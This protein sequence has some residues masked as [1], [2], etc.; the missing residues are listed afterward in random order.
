MESDCRRGLPAA[1]AVIP[2]LKEDHMKRRILSLLLAVVMVAGM[3]PAV[4]AAQAPEE[5]TTAETIAETTQDPATEEVTDAEPL[6]RREKSEIAVTGDGYPAVTAI[7][8]T[9][10]GLKLTWNAFPGA[11]KYQVFLRKEAGGWK[12]IGETTATSYLHKKLTNNT[13]YTYT[14]RAV[15]KKGDFISEGRSYSARW[16]QVPELLRCESTPSGQKLVWKSVEGAEAYRIF[17][18]S[19]TKWLFAGTTETS[20]CINSRVTSGKAY[21]Y[22]VRCWDVDADAPLSY[23]DTKGIIGAYYSTP[24]ITAFNAV[25]GGVSI[26]WSKVSGATYYAVFRKLSKGWKKLGVTSRLSMNDLGIRY[27]ARYTYTVRCVNSQGKPISGYVKNGWSF[28]HLAAPKITSVTYRDKVYTI[29]WKT[30]QTASYYRVYRKELGAGWTCLGNTKRNVFADKKAAKEGV[31]TYAIR[32]MDAAGNYLTYFTDTGVYYKMGICA[33]GPLNGEQP[34][35]NPRYTC[36]VSEAQLRR[37]VATVASGWQGANEGSIYHSEILSFYNSRRPLAGNHTV[38]ASDPWAAAFA[39][40]VWIRA[41]LSQYIGAEY[42][43]GRFV[44]LAKK[45]KIWVESDSYLPKVGDAIVYSWSDTGIGE[46]TS[47]ANHMGIV[48]AVNGSDFVVTEGD[49]GTGYVGTH[50]RVVNSQYIRGYIAPNYKQ[51]AQYISLKARYS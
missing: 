13:V 14:V 17:I 25:N 34:D 38:Q 46:C 41:G 44:E 27:S 21:A 33:V 20:Y 28:T 18:K 7:A 49:A 5:E 10:T 36:A 43:C 37:M 9:V 29:R 30:Q 12:K 23:F 50:D 15:N 42:S 1:A 19:G 40:A 8:P 48:T 47:S 32:T 45:N 22:T 2:Y 51:I 16:L 31:Y 35:T 3:I 39:S 6:L 11:A 26:T 4:T 24:R